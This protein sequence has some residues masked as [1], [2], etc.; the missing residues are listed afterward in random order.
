MND[1]NGEIFSKEL[2]LEDDVDDEENETPRKK[3]K[4]QA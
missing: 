2:V 3:L 1:A 4:I